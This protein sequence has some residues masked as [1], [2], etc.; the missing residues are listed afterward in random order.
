MASSG[1]PLVTGWLWGGIWV[2]TL[3]QPTTTWTDLLDQSVIDNILPWFDQIT[4]DATVAEIQLISFSS[5]PLIGTFDVNLDGHSVT[6]NFDDVTGD[7]GTAGS[8]NYKIASLPG[9]SKGPSGVEVT[10]SLA[11]QAI[12]VEFFTYVGV[13][14]LSISNNTTGVTITVSTTQDASGPRST[15]WTR[16]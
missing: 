15:T 16:F 4:E 14:S 12:A 7:L 3:A 1:F 2:D 10:G 8:I 5:A 11:L 6:I 9:I 13:P